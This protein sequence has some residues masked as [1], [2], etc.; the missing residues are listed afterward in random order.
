[1]NSFDKRKKFGPEKCVVTLKLP[2]INKNSR[3]LAK[4]VKQL[5]KNTYNAA[6]PR[7]IL[8]SKLLIQPSVKDPISPSI[9]V[10]LFTSSAAFVKQAIL[11]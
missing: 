8:T 11:G 2:F 5:I 1:M 9:K 3:V 6:D 4:N 7:I 10:W